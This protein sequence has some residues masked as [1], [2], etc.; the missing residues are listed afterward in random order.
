MKTKEKKTDLSEKE[1]SSKETAIFLHMPFEDEEEKEKLTLSTYKTIQRLFS[2]NGISLL[3]D[4]TYSF[5]ENTEKKFP[6]ISYD[7]SEKYFSFSLLTYAKYRQ[8]VDGFISD[9]LTRWLQPGQRLSIE[10]K[11]TTTFSFIFAPDKEFFLCQYHILISEHAKKNIMKHLKAFVQNIRINILAVFHSSRLTMQNKLLKE[12][13][14]SEVQN[15]NLQAKIHSEKKLSQIEKSLAQLMQKR[16]HTFDWDIYKTIHH[17]TM[18]FPF[19]FTAIRDT[20]HVSRIIGFQYFFKKSI[21]QDAYSE[22]NRRHVRLKIFKSKVHQNQISYPVIGILISLNFSNIAERFDKTHLLEAIWYCLPDVKYVEDSYIV[23][24]SDEKIRSY[25]LEVQKK[26]ITAEEI[27]LLKHRL[28]EECKGRIENVVHPIFMP[29]NEEEV[30][31]NII[32]LSKQ[33]KYVRDLP[34]VIINY[35]HQRGKDVVFT[36][37]LLRLLKHDSVPLKELFNRSDTFLKFHQEEIKIVGYL[38]KKYPKEA[39]LFKLALNRSPFIRRDNFLDLQKTRQCVV[40]ELIKVL[41]DFRDY[42]GGMI[43]KQSQALDK[44][45]E[46]LLPKQKEDEL[47]LEDFF[48]SLKPALMQSILSTEVIKSLYLLFLDIKKQNFS[49]DRFY[50]K[51]DSHKQYFLVMIAVKDS[52]YKEEMENEIKSLNIPSFDLTSCFVSLPECCCFGYILRNSD[53]AKRSSFYRALLKAMKKSPTFVDSIQ[54]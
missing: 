36:I 13:T 46:L 26:D 49:E 25:Y 8:G 12:R 44:L 41:G 33:L 35:D 3:S 21:M 52:S 22:P 10:G 16:S 2:E 31:R 15:T 50:I 45:K 34:Q 24:K 39:N 14:V 42:N 28:P 27:R 32:L 19:Q 48:Y 23:D 6:L 37:I 7:F 54:S 53:S 43:F 4:S 29:R 11:K 20:N 40:K 18:Q 30:L 9:M 17:V 51:T 1:P 47:M 38:K 5:F